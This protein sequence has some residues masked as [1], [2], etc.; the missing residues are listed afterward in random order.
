[1]DF[2]NPVDFI[3][4]TLERL[5]DLGNKTIIFIDEFEEL[6]NEKSTLKEIISGLKDVLNNQFIEIGKNGKF[7]SFIH[8]IIAVTPNAFYKLESD[9]DISLIFGGLGRRTGIINLPSINKEEAIYFLQDLMK[10]CYNNNLPDIFP[11]KNL[12]I[13]N[14]LYKITLGNLGNMVS[15]F[16]KLLSSAK[17]DDSKMRII[18]YQIFIDFLIKQTIFVYGAKTPCISDENY[19]KIISIIK[20][21]TNKAFGEMCEKIFKLLI[22]EYKPFTINEISSRLNISNIPNKINAINDDLT[23]KLRLNRAIIK[24]IKIDNNSFNKLLNKMSNFTMRE[25][26]IEYFQI[27]NYIE[28]ISKFKE[29][30]TYHRYL[31]NNIFSELF[32][33]R[34][35]NDIMIFFEGINEDRAQELY[36][37]FRKISKNDEIY[38]LISDELLTQIYPTPLPI[39]L[40]FI[41]SSEIKLNLWR[42]ISKNLNE[43]YRN[44]FISAALLIFNKSDLLSINNINNLSNNCKH[45][46]LQYENMNISTLIYT[47]IGD[48]NS[49]EINSIYNYYISNKKPVHL[50][51]TFYDGEITEHA[52]DNIENKE[53]GEKGNNLLIPIKIYPNL[54][55]KLLIIYKTEIED[56]EVDN[57][58]LLKIIQNILQEEFKF[59]DKINKWIE[60]Q[61]N[62]GLIV[63]DPI[64]EYASSP[65]ELGNSLKFYIN[66]MNE[67]LTPEESYKKNRMYLLKFIKYGSKKGFIP[68]IESDSALI[69]MTYD[70][71]EN[72]FLRKTQN[73]KFIVINH[74][75]EEKILYLIKKY[76]NKIT[77]TEL[78]NFFLI[79][80][81]NKNIL[82]NLFFN[83]LEHKGFIDFEKRKKMIRLTNLHEIEEILEENIRKI[84]NRIKDDQLKFGFFYIRKQRESKYINISEFLEFIRNN[85]NEIK[86]IYEI[87]QKI[88][89]ITLL[90]K[91]INYFNGEWIELL[92][93]VI[94]FLDN[95]LE[96]LKIDLKN[97]EMKINDLCNKLKS[98]FKYDLDINNI[99]E[100]V[101]INK[102]M[103]FIY[104]TIE[105]NE[106]D[107]IKYRFEKFLDNIEDNQ[108]QKFNYNYSENEPPY[109]NIK[110]YLIILKISEIDEI[111]S[112]LHNNIDM[113]NQNINNLEN[114]KKDFNKNIISKEI[115]ENFKYSHNLLKFLKKHI[116][117]TLPTYELYKINKIVSIIDVK[118]FVNE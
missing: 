31:N 72:N 40:D 117:T 35:K 21:K 14:C 85:N 11:I 58:V 50:I 78:F 44:N 43:L 22:G 84:E 74:P 1:L 92:D 87:P 42:N 95:K 41:K 69:Q 48:L 25:N 7:E 28:E 59:V 9:P 68:D 63:D 80:S 8:L 16:S 46:F 110:L 32:L 99:D 45:L 106:F 112:K 118:N 30:I 49:S 76:D 89:K 5:R 65:K 6:L 3:L 115:D 96:S 71:L 94:K 27:N 56:I 52:L 24:M 107:D 66:F 97:L 55:K 26:N 57:K 103:E 47:A 93:K 75:V 13:F 91:L 33:P 29:R 12:G 15:L 53:L 37:I 39:G 105:M 64:L 34:D 81:S 77:Y 79:K 19:R 62:K 98:W 114:N 61:I 108:I 104:K 23:K 83:I 36:N 88:Q 2:N 101:K 116:D 60:N 38:Y 20:D 111:Y 90:N 51:I 54:I 82:Q 4:E 70:L 10:Y 17:I 102:N 100:I 67:P 73:N 113:I 18:D 109:F 86:N